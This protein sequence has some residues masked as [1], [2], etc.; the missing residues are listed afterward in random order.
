M[1]KQ[2]IPRI[3]Y[4]YWNSKTLPLLIEKCYKNIQRM[5][6][7]WTVKLYSA[8][9]IDKIKNKP[10]FMK[11]NSN[12]LSEQKDKIVRISD[13]FRLYMLEKYGGVYLDIS[14]I[15]LR[16]LDN[17]F[18]V[19]DNRMQA[20][21]VPWK[22]IN[23]IENFCIASPPHN[24]VIK[25]WLNETEIAYI[26]KSNYCE[27][28]HMHAG[29]LNRHLPYL[30]QH[31]AWMKVNSTLNNKERLK[32]YTIIGDGDYKNSPYFWLNMEDKPSSIPKLLTYKQ[33]NTLFN[34]KTLIKLNSIHRNILVNII[35]NDKV[36][37][38]SY[39]ASILNINKQ[40]GTALQNKTTLKNKPISK[41]KKT[42]K[43][44]VNNKNIVKT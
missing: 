19:N 33:Q 37:Y 2:K 43:I 36:P 32:Y 20:F 17:L 28:N 22:N 31:L 23:A 4:L 21:H 15:F 3:I 16:N 13:W 18:D 14:I 9:D 1:V 5:N 12:L 6:K 8:S 27:I 24:K 30:T 35:D 39:I 41:N 38:N 25:M 10:E 40:L 7:N 34:N 29:N 42:F 44:V 11:H 26:D